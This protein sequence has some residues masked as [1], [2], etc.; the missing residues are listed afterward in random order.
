MKRLSI[1]GLLR[2]DDIKGV[3]S[4]ILGGRETVNDVAGRIGEC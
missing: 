4:G 3:V 1:G 2:D